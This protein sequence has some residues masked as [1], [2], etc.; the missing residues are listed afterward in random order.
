MV[1]GGKWREE[2]FREGIG[3]DL[4][5]S[6]PIHQHAFPVDLGVSGSGGCRVLRYLSRVRVPLDPL[7]PKC[8]YRRFSRL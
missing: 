2:V 1:D 4:G 3:T 5:G 8:P 6:H 7:R